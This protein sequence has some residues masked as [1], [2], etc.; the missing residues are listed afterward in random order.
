MAHFVIE[1]TRVHFKIWGLEVGDQ[2]VFY[3]CKR[4]AP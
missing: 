2:N 1:Y 4:Q 3:Q